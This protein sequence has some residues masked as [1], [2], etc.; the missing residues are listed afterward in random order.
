M[1]KKDRNKLLI[2]A[3]LL[4]GGYLIYRKLAPA[5]TPTPTAKASTPATATPKASTPEQQLNKFIA[6]KVTVKYY[7]PPSAIMTIQYTDWNG[8]SQQIDVSKGD[9]IYIK[10]LEGTDSIANLVFIDGT[11]YHCEGE[12]CAT[13]GKEVFK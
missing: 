2:L 8:I 5:P 13:A 7:C 12:D 3:A 6:K 10:C 4:L 9:S 11:P 1:E